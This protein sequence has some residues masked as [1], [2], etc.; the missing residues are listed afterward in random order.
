MRDTASL[1]GRAIAAGL[2]EAAIE[3]RLRQEKLMRVNV[4]VRPSCGRGEAD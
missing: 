4:K 2:S 3:D 1:A